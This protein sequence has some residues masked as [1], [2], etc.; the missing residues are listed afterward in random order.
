MA[1][2]RVCC[3]LVDVVCSLAHQRRALP[4]MDAADSTSASPFDT[5]EHRRDVVALVVFHKAQMQGIPHL[6]R[7]CQSPRV[8]TQSTRTVLTSGDGVEVPYSRAS[9]HQ[10]TFVSRVSR[11]WNI[12]TAADPHTQEM[13]THRVKLAANDWRRSQSIL[14][15]LII[16]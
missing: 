7:L 15:T 14:L 3:F 10:R 12:S 13:N 11:M 9:Q 8:A 5:L 1:L 6:A 2:L 4:L 16:L